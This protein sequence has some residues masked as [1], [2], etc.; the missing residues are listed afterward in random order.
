MIYTGPFE[1]EIQNGGHE[2][3]VVASCLVAKENQPAF[4]IDDAPLGDG[5]S[6]GILSVKYSDSVLD[7]IRILDVQ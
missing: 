1:K 2:G 4:A 6:N 7:E 5:N 3:G